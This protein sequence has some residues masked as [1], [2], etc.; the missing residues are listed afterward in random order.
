MEIF[1]IIVWW[2]NNMAGMTLDL[3][4]FERQ[5]EEKKKQ[6]LLGMQECLN[7]KALQD[8]LKGIMHFYIQE[9]VYNVY[10][11]KVY[12]RTYDLL[13]SVTATVVDDTLYIYVDDTGMD[14]PNG[15]WS[16]PWRVILGDDVYPYDHPIKGAAFMNPRDWRYVTL[17]ELQNHSEQSGVLLGII[18]S[19]IQKRI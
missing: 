9:T 19:I 2:R 13:N 18:T 17:A 16:Y 4:G 1:Y 7:S 14:K 6:I 10:N 15:Q 8:Y 3:K 12:E 11:P 5:I